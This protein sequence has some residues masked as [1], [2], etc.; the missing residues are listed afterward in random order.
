MF[1]RQKVELPLSN[2][3]TTQSSTSSHLPPEIAN[4]MNRVRNFSADGA[5]NQTLQNLSQHSD[6]SNRKHL[7]DRDIPS[8]MSEHRDAPKESVVY[9]SL[10]K[11]KITESVLEA[12]NSQSVERVNITDDNYRETDRER[13]HRERHALTKKTGPNFDGLPQ[14]VH[15]NSY[16]SKHQVSQVHNYE[17]HSK[18]M[19][20]FRKP[21]SPS[22]EFQLPPSHQHRPKAFSLPRGQMPNDVHHQY[23]L[24]Q[25]NDSNSSH[26]STP[27][28]PQA[29]SDLTVPVYP[30]GVERGR[31]HGGNLLR[32]PSSPR[33]QH[34]PIES[35]NVEGFFGHRG[36]K[37]REREHQQFQVGKVD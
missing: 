22:E 35:S 28:T 25:Q 20:E 10:S 9:D 19:N 26:G 13:E 36:Y 14:T 3:N 16:H 5:D 34:W 37:V 32:S 8:H 6:S 24:H 1:S 21:G 33:Q 30:Q 11:V 7:N 17:N 27:T 29:Q 12:S 31:Y 2:D 15:A 23:H 4:F 18:Q